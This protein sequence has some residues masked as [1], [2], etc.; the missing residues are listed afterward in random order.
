MKNIQLTIN[1]IEKSMN[2]IC[3]NVNKRYC[4]PFEHSSVKQLLQNIS[5][6]AFD[7]RK[8]NDKI[9][10]DLIEIKSNLFMDRNIVNLFALGRLKQVIQNI[11]H[12][13]DKDDF[14]QYIDEKI[15]IVSK[16]KFL[17]GHYA[18]SVKSA[19]TE[20]CTI[21]RNFRKNNNYKELPSEV[22]MFQNTFSNGKILK[23]A[24]GTSISEKNIQEGYEKIVIG[25]LLA[26]RN[27]NSHTNNYINK[28][29]AIDKLFIA[30]ELI[31]IIDISISDFYTK[32]EETILVST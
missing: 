26:I 28:N 12:Y 8:Y 18:D 16:R 1:N 3:E 25:S 9:S 13:Y 27:P 31:K 17:D 22:D 2:F 30:N 24:E 5:E 6:L 23:F 7:I 20:I 14:W 29:D 32:Q 19:F 21:I 15:T 4:G 10:S 11:S